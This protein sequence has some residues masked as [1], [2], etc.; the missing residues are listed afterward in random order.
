MPLYF[1]RRS[2]RRPKRWDDVPP[3][4]PPHP[5]IFSQEPTIANADSRL[6]AASFHKV[7]AAKGQTTI[8]SLFFDVSSFRPPNTGTNHGATKTDLGRLAWDHRVPRRHVLGALLTC[9]WSERAKPPRVGQRRLILVV[10]CCG[11]V[12][13]VGVRSSPPPKNVERNILWGM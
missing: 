12:V 9:P 4:A 7:S 2:N 1:F 10:V 6:V 8:P 5:R 13:C 11:C 3:R